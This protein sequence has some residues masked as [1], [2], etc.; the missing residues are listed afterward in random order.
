MKFSEILKKK[1]FCPPSKLVGGGEKELFSSI[2]N[3]EE[4]KEEENYE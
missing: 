1:T 2:S 3:A 4:T